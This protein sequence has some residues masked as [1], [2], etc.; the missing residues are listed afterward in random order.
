MSARN[1]LVK[2]LPGPVAGALGKLGA[3][4]RTARLRRNL[5]VQQIADRVGVSRQLVADAEHGKP[6]TGIAVYVAMLWALG[7]IDQLA[8]V[9][10]PGKDGVGLIASIS[11]DRR[12]ARRASGTED[13]S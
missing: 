10:D 1:V 8:A 5:T 12:R 2:K 6:T 11:A 3:N 7:L 13:D 9:A 4:L